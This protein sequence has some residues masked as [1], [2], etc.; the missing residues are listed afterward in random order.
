MTR[1]AFTKRQARIAG[2]CC[3]RCAKPVSPW[4]LRRADLCHTAGASVCPRHWSDI[5]AA[6]ARLIVK[7]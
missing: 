2:G 4:P 7:D 5:L 1:N 3:P 6:E